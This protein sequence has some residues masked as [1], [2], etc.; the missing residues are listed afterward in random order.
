MVT[1][2][3]NNTGGYL[4][5][6]DDALMVAPE[7]A[8][9]GLNLILCG[10]SGALKASV[11]NA[12][13]GYREF[14]P[15]V[16]ECV[17]NQG[18]V[19]GRWVSLVELPALYELPQEVV[20]EE[21]FKC[22]SLCDPEGAR[23]FI[24]VLPVG[25][26]TLNDKREI[27]T[28]Q[29]T[30]SH[31]VN[32]F[33]IILFT[34]ESNPNSP[35]VVRFLRQSSD[36][37]ELCQ[38]C[39]GRYVVFNLNDKH[40]VFHVLH[41]VERMRGSEPRCFTKEMI[42]RPPRNTV[43][44]RVSVLRMS[45]FKHQRTECLRIVLV[46]KTGCGKSA[47]GNTIL[48]REY[49]T[50]KVS[51][52]SVTQVCM[53]ATGLIAGRPIVVVD[54][55][56]LFDTTLSNDQVKQELVK[57]VSMSAPGPH[58]FL[59]VLQI[60]RF[61]KEEKETVDL[62][63]KFFGKKSGDFIIVIFTRG[64]ELKGQ[65]IESYIEDCEDFVK[66]LI[67]DCGDRYHVFNNNDKNNHAQ[68][69]Q[70][71]TKVESMVNRNGGGYYTSEMFQEAEAAIQREVERI[72]K[73]KEE[74]IQRQK[75]DLERKHEEEIQMSQ[76]K[77]EEQRPK[78]E[79]E[80][81]QCAK[82]L[83][84]KE[85]HIKKE[86]EKTKR[87]EEQRE[88]EERERKKQEESQRQ[89]WEEKLKDAF[90]HSM[91]IKT[92]HGDMQNSSVTQ[93]IRDCNQRQHKINFDKKDLPDY[94]RQELI[95][96]ME[97][98]VS[99][100]RRQY[101]ICT[102]E[103]DPMMTPESSKPPPKHDLQ[104]LID[105]TENIMSDNK[106]GHL[107]CTEGADPMTVSITS[108]APMNLVLCGRFGA[109]KTSAANA[110]LG[111]RKFGPSTDSKS[112]KNQGEVCGRWVSLVEL[113]ALYGKPQEAVMEESFRC[114]SLCDPE[115]IHAF[116]LVL[117]VG[118]LTDEDKGELET[119]QNTFGSRV[120][121]FT[122]ILFIVEANPNSPAVVRFL[123]ENMLIQELCQSCRGRYF[124][125][126]L[127]D[128]QQVF[129]VLHTVERMRVVEP[130]CF[131]KE[132]ITR[133]RRNIVKKHA[134]VLMTS[135]YSNECRESLRIVLVGKTGCGKSATGNTILGREHFTSEVSSQSVTKV[136]TKATGE[137]D[138][139]PV[140]VVDTPGLFD[141]TVS[142]EK[143][144]EE[145]V[146][147]VSMLAP[148]PHVFLLVLQIGCFTKEEKETVELIKTFF[149]KNAE[150]FII[151]LFTREDDLKGQT[152]ESYIEKSEE[153]KKLIADCGDRY[154]V[155][156]NND[157]NNHAQVSQLLTKVES[158]VNRKGGGYYTSE[159]FQEAEAAI[160][161]EVA[162]IKKVK[163]EEIQRHKRDLERKHL[164][165]IKMSKKKREE[166][167][168]K[169]EQE[170]A[171][172]AKQLKE[173]NEYIK[174]EQE[175]RRRE[176]EQREE[177]ERERKK[178]EEI[179]RQQWEEKL[180]AL[181]QKIKLQSQ[182]KETI[183]RKLRESKEEIKT[184]Q[185][186]WEQERKEWWQ[187]QCKED[188][189]R[190]QEERIRLEK[191]RKEYEQEKE[192]YEFRRKYEDQIRKDQEDTEW[193]GMQELFKKRLNEL[194]NKYEEEARKQAE[195]CNDFKEKYTKDFAA[196]LEQHDQEM[197][198]LKQ[199]QQRSNDS[200]IKQLTKNKAFEKDFDRL[201][202]KHEQEMN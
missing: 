188:E 60:G 26:L 131:T 124:V 180:N 30:F 141:T 115:G 65:T 189:Q 173:K 53:K 161:K 117:P 127:T 6:N 129:H 74:E 36:I 136:C 190:R 45:S 15:S 92:Q 146:K 41:T 66:K 4:S 12:I 123:K 82:V 69:S 167:K 104:E 185:E 186:A 78:I 164:E 28:I 38:S 121:D 122:T 67:A 75:R 44:R 142:N 171:L 99:D 196:L 77:R 150:D 83:R 55:P 43:T 40:Q 5:F 11:A 52:K 76:K 85:E 39:G 62:I 145:L 21:S 50:S 152:I 125:F 22:I 87:E 159:M 200:I 154:H 197:A 47:T 149:G 105:Q 29:N 2:V 181:E 88:V 177:E 16:Y 128:K 194:E 133:P 155:F 130:R 98:I 64:D 27:Q 119:I 107:N 198:A 7:S 33:T 110:I 25:P 147:C 20:L 137:I 118:P 176:E 126:D 113:P 46:G 120:N 32:D 101:L 109:W 111:E 165:E 169:I 56:G 23:A 18:E 48:G 182:E 58:V 80:R 135:S 160:Q 193:R 158:M 163:E 37:Q 153:V 172:R 201:K 35:A 93:I 143:I 17:K 106:G 162:R 195:E 184:Q 24:L 95:E 178:Q 116:I 170:R 103:A 108:K 57:C 187:K 84:E 51:S 191:L 70:L 102:E 10:R 148:G 86:Q 114:I 183:N 168:P 9:E 175:K 71:L 156:N 157:K 14:G 63:K 192:N 139:Q 166:Q 8:K 151:I 112:V 61:T 3:G 81:A 34:V 179:Q 91:V 138:G 13:L 144:E 73:A 68:V 19:C 100:N 72:K 79:Q 94:D 49:F 140:T 96:K 134:S 97:N 202:K 1:M 54:T 42:T 89:Q 59:L 31:R 132:M 174:K 90:K 199:M